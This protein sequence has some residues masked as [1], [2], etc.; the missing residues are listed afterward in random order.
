MADADPARHLGAAKLGGGELTLRVCS[1]LVLA[2]LAIGIA[3]VGGWLFTAFWGLAAIGVLWEWT[4]LVAGDD[5]RAVLMAGGASVVLAVAL[6]G[7]V[8]TADGV[9]EVR[10]L[11]A[12]TVLAMGMLGVAALAPKDVRAWV[13]VGIPYAGLIG[14]APIVLRSDVE[15]GFAAVIFLFAIVWGTDIVAY[16]TGRALGGPKLAPTISPKK[17]W[18]GAIGGTMAAIVVAV[19]IAKVAGLANVLALCSIAVMLSVVAQAGDL[20]ESALKRRF[21][22]KDSGQLIPGHGGLMDRL[23]GFVM[24][25]VLAALIGLARAGVEAPARGLLIW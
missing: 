5:R 2:P 8:N 11:A 18:S 17:T 23:D 6:T 24:A 20:F 9:H 4:S 7:A 13:A 25:A 15:Y 22:A 12:I 10:L 1:A 16:F 3:Y 19:I 21:G 14:I